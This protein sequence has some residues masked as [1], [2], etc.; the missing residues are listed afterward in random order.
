MRQATLVLLLKDHQILLAMKKRGFG[1]GKWNGVGGKLK[2]GENIRNAAAREAKEEIGVE[3]SE[4]SQ[5][6]I[7][8]FFFPHKPE[9]DQQVVV[10]VASSWEGEPSESEEMMPKWFGFDEIPYDTMWF[11]DKHWLPKVLE[12]KNVKAKF[13]FAEDESVMEMKIEE[14]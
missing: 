8:D 6:G 1:Q 11:D 3:I 12:G 9:W 2:D 4:F 7:I 13:V 5:V 14:G 10:Y